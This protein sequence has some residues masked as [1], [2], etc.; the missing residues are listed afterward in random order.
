MK[1][2]ISGK[3]GVGKT[4]LAALLAV[5]FAND[6][7]N[8][9]AV[10]ADP[11]SNL[12]MALGFSREELDRIVPISKMDEL[13]LE[14]TGAKKGATGAIFRLNPK[15][16]DI[17]EKYSLQKDGVRLLVMG[18]VSVGGGGCACPEN[19]L[20]RNLLMHLIVERN[21][22][23]I[24]DMEAG[25]EHLGRGTAR[26]V[27]AFIVV[28]EPGQRSFQTARA[29][30][31]LAGDLGITR[32]YLVA[33]KVRQEEREEIV[34]AAG[35]LPLLGMLPYDENAIIADLRGV[36]VYEA[37]PVL[38]EEAARVKEAIEARLG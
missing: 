12:G 5:L 20:L 31:K 8:V 38:V 26:A 30:A 34:R 6:G 7:K 18:G 4:T 29:V 2:A 24:V 9:L 14:R 35:E 11:D 17:P 19:T 16:D 37:C 28:I 27:D 15:V 1:L 33:N 22:T 23:V 21:E 36:P 13:I 25:L 32:V 3:G 10:D